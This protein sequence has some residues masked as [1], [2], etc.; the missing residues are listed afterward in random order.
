MN[1]ADKFKPPSGREVARQCRDGG[2]L[3]YDEIS[4]YFIVFAFSLTR[5]AGA[6]SR[7]EPFRLRILLIVIFCIRFI[8]SHSVDSYQRS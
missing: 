4:F 3:R 5:F 2:S 6:P 1:N 7:R 8:S